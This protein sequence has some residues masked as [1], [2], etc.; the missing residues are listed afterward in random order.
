MMP[1]RERLK[2]RLS[3]SF[4]REKRRWSQVKGIFAFIRQ[5]PK[6]AFTFFWRQSIRANARDFWLLLRDSL[7]TRWTRTIVWPVKTALWSPDGA[8]LV[9]GQNSELQLWNAHTGMLLRSFKVM[10]NGERWWPGQE[11][12]GTCF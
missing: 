7:R 9:V 12:E 2:S 11:M 1:L 10:A 6:M 5:N 3:Q 4:E 8:Y